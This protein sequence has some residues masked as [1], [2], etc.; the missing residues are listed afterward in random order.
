VNTLFRRGRKPV[1]FLNKDTI[2]KADEWLLQEMS[3]QSQEAQNALEFGLWTCLKN[4]NAD[5]AR[6]YEERFRSSDHAM[7]H[8]LHCYKK[9]ANQQLEKEA[10]RFDY[11]DSLRKG[12]LAWYLCALEVNV[13]MPYDAKMIVQAVHAKRFLFATHL[14]ASS[15]YTHTFYD[16]ECMLKYGNIEML[17]WFQ[18]NVLSQGSN[19]KKYVM[20][21]LAGVGN[22]EAFRY[23][24]E[25]KKF[26][27]PKNALKYSKT[28]G[29]DAMVEYIVQRI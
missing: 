23:F 27:I 20:E 11:W 25:E 9:A 12:N 7:M 3:Y 4:N 26:A 29:H 18:K 28:N 2:E 14:F 10:M 13:E 5:K 6:L 17:K 16:Y 8:R 22:L 19:G 24:H 21:Y 1:M 15:S